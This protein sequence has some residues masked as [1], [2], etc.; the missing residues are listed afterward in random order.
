MWMLEDIGIF[1][2][3]NSPKGKNIRMGR[4]RKANWIS[5]I[6]NVNVVCM[7][8][9]LTSIS[10]G[11]AGAIPSK[12]DSPP[13]DVSIIGVRGKDLNIAFRVW[14]ILV[15]AA[16]G[17]LSLP[18]DRAPV[19]GIKPKRVDAFLTSSVLNEGIT[20]ICTDFQ[21]TNWISDIPPEEKKDPIGILENW[22]SIDTGE[23]GKTS[24][25][26]SYEGNN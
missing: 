3:S 23:S 19:S 12:V 18:P 6:L 22:T 8:A 7:T 1:S 4:T 17:A 14:D 5:S 25:I 10:E 13:P 24:M 11:S 21:T 15:T 20:R 16:V 9:Q 2:S 26:A